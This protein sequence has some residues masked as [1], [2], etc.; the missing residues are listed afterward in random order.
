[1]SDRSK[2]RK[3]W[4]VVFALCALLLCVTE[5]KAQ[6]I[7]DIVGTVTDASGAVLPNATVTVK[8]LETNAARSVASSFLVVILV[9]RALPVGNYSV[10]VQAQGF[11]DVF[12]SPV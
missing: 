6:G 9:S 7:A 10:T 5:A 2:L 11:Q 1:M 8:S 3:A 4:L 12:L